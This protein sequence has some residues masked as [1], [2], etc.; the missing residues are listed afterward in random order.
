MCE[1]LYFDVPE[2]DP[3]NLHMDPQNRPDRS[4][5][6]IEHH[7]LRCLY[8]ALGIKIRL[9][10][11]PPGL[12][13][14]TFTANLGLVIGKKVLISNFKPERR[15]G[16]SRYYREFLEKLGYEIH[17]LPE[18]IFFEGAG[19]ALLY[20]DKILCGYGFRTSKAAIPYVEKL[21]GKEVVPVQLLHPGDGKKILYHLDTACMVFEGPKALIIH[22][23]VL[24][25]ESLKR[26]E[27]LA[28][29]FPASYEDAANLAL[30]AVVVPRPELKP[31]FLKTLKMPSKWDIAL[32]VVV[33]SDLAS[34]A[35][36]YRIR[37][38]GYWP[39]TMSLAEFLKSGGGAFCLTKIL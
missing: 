33:T 21:A 15:R 23:E 20:R 12:V 4:K 27:N 28:T 39:V 25:P 16:E 35:L 17:T 3:D 29:V 13:D 30:N 7:Q 26:L 6:V 32:G 31:N 8:E 38:L 11:P 18:G 2:T 10:P 1:P 14:I 19:D 24:S 37:R 5:A 22:R 9:L 36:K 34:E